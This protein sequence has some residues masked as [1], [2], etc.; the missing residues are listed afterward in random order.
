MREG[1][2]KENPINISLFKKLYPGTKIPNNAYINF[3]DKL[4]FLKNNKL[5]FI[6]ELSQFFT[7]RPLDEKDNSS[8][9]GRSLKKQWIRQW[10]LEIQAQ[11]QSNKN[12]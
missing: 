6:E 2:T 8:K 3:N 9:P 1:Y 5:N 11:K 12:M 7:R 10:K 4:Y